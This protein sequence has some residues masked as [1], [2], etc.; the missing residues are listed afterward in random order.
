MATSTRGFRKTPPQ[1]GTS[2]PLPLQRGCP[3]GH[4]QESPPATTHHRPPRSF[5]PAQFE[6]IHQLWGRGAGW[7]DMGAG[8]SFHDLHLRLSLG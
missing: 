1:V 4:L 6:I 7:L 2:A 5:C 3:R 8:D